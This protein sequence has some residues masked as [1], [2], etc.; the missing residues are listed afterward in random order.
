MNKN[1][2]V[3]KLLPISWFKK[4]IQGLCLKSCSLDTAVDL[5]VLLAFRIKLGCD[6]KRTPSWII[7]FSAILGTKIP[8]FDDVV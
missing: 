3:F 5:K 8:P 2:F 6:G 4:K 1:L 7:T